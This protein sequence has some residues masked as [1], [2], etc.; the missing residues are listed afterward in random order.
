MKIALKTKLICGP[1]EKEKILEFLRLEQ[2]IFNFCSDKFYGQKVNSIKILHNLCYHSAKEKFPNAK[3]QL[4]IKSEQR[5]L[6]VYRSIK[7]NKHKINSPPVKKRLSIQLDKR[8]FTFKG[9][10]FTLTTLGRRVKCDF[11]KY[12]KLIKAFS[13][14]KLCD[15]S[16]LVKN[17]EI[18]I[19]FVFYI[20]TEEVKPKLAVGVDLGY[21]R[22]AATSEG[23]ILIDK[24][25]N[26]QRRHIRYLK[27]CLQ[28]KGS[29]SAKRHLN[30]VRHKEHNMSKNFNHHLANAILDTK[31]NVI[32][33]EDLKVN[34]LK[35]NKHKGK[36]SNR[37][38]QVC[39]S[40]LRRIL[41]YKAA[42]KNKL[43]VCVNPKFTSK[44]D[45]MSDKEGIRKGCRFYSS[46]GLVYDSDINAAINIAKRSKLP[47]SQGNLLDG[48]A[49]IKTPIVNRQ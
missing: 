41:T 24:N 13:Q 27:R 21:R 20:P 39:L 12:D 43:V 5:V 28:S 32:V 35:K 8:L 2:D 38:T 1:N 7:S 9:D 36:N 45:C 30:K 33:I 11:V 17:G 14:G 40:E 10:Y 4:I 22:Y 46:N 25:Y 6:S 49:S 31:A 44:L 34:K 16:L 19:Q 47:F 29:R 3:S 48:Q 37:K 18:Y 42:L 26:K 15:P 23:K